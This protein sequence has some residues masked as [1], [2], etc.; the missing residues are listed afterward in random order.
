VQSSRARSAIAAN[1]AQTVIA[2]NARAASNPQ[3]AGSA[4]AAAA[5]AL[6]RAATI[7]VT[8]KA[9]FNE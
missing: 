6:V 9:F 7:A 5:A 1:P 3:T 2:A 4:W 8:N